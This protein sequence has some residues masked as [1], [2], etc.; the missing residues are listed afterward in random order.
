MVNKRNLA[1]DLAKAFGIAL[2]VLGHVSGPGEGTGLLNARSFVYQF[3]VPLF[4]FLSGYFFKE[5]ETWKVFITK[6]I[7]RLYIPFV[8]W[9][10]IFFAVHILTH[11]AAG[12]GFTLIDTLKHALKIVLG[13]A[14]TPLGGATW[15]LITLLQSLILY[16]ALVAFIPKPERF[17]DLYIVLLALS[18]G[19]LGSL[20][21]LPWNLERALV[22]LPFVCAG[23]LARKKVLLERIRPVFQIL[24]A[25]IGFAVIL[26]CSRF[27]RP[28]I[29]V[30]QYGFVPI[31]WVAAFI[32]IFST[33]LFCSWL[34][35]FEQLT[36][37]SEWGQWTLWILIGHFAAFKLVS[38]FQIES[39]SHAWEVLFAHPCNFVGGWWAVAYFFC[40]FF[41][42][43][44]L[45]KLY[46]AWH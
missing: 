13:I 5:E 32:G 40:G 22:A 4:F 25:I 33:L 12:E 11:L 35:R 37:I 17:P 30:H 39:A 2:V 45:S 6:R 16:K 20:I 41:L 3:H 44:A 42:P 14:I 34:S 21:R 28:D 46:R 1:I 10:L 8:L 15:F 23:H 18:L 7:K 31:F 38:L 24:L 27:N 19:I 26:L 29:A 43:L 36:F 9:N